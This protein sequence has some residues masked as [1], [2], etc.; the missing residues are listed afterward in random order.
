ME[1][2]TE[3]VEYFEKYEPDYYPDVELMGALLERGTVYE[4]FSMYHAIGNY[5]QKKEAPGV[6][7]H[8]YPILFFSSLRREDLEDEWRFSE[9]PYPKGYTHGTNE[10]GQILRRLDTVYD[11]EEAKETHFRRAY[12]GEITKEDFK[13]PMWEEGEDELS[14]YDH[15]EMDQKPVPLRFFKSLDKHMFS[16]YGG[17]LAH[18]YYIKDDSGIY[19]KDT[20]EGPVEYQR[21]LVGVI[22]GMTDVGLYTGRALATY[23]APYLDGWITFNPGAAR[24]AGAPSYTALA[25]PFGAHRNRGY[26]GPDI[27][28]AAY[29]GPGP[30]YDYDY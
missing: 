25:T 1:E 9:Y 11:D 20:A 16:L 15:R 27:S 21:F 2:L 6:D 5:L 22:V 13:L 17:T 14:Q 12:T 18:G 26:S 3:L 10:W 23:L 7:V 28:D 24:P 8:I 29:S 30:G 4:I 19:E